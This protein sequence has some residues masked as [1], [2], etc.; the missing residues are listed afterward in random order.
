LAFARRWPCHNFDL[1][2][3]YVFEFDANNG[4][5]VDVDKYIDGKYTVPEET[6][7]GPEFVALSEDACEF[8]A[9]ELGLSSVLEIRFGEKSGPR[10]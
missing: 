7:D 5:L 1:D 9:R 10:P 3:E 4:D 2:A 6:E 8:G